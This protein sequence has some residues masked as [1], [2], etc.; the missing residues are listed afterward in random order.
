MKLRVLILTLSESDLRNE[1]DGV[2]QHTAHVALM[3]VFVR[4]KLI[5][6]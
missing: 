6:L 3:K 5:F 4:D 1:R 2:V